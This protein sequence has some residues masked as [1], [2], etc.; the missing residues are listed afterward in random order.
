MRLLRQSIWV[1]GMAACST[2]PVQPVGLHVRIEPSAAVLAAGDSLRVRVTISNESS[3][4]QQIVGVSCQAVVD[5]YSTSANTRMPVYDLRAC[6]A[7]AGTTTVP[8]HGALSDLVTFATTQQNGAANALT[9]GVY[10]LQG[11]MSV[12]G[13]GTLRSEYATIAVSE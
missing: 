11:R 6:I 13:F 9:E 10:R 7:V 4:P 8:P 2:G 1:L 5:V 3:E 12:L